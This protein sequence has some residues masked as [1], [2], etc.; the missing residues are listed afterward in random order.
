MTMTTKTRT[1]D[2]KSALKVLSVLN[3]L[4]RNFAYGFT[5]T[6]LQR[7]T[8]LSASNITVYTNTLINAG[9]AERIP[10][11]DRVRP[12]HRLAQQAIKILHSLDDAQKRIDESRN[13]LLRG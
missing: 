7:E 11:T 13:R 8:G 9:F 10:E 4:M 2:T 3:V 12:I 6:E 1:P 5:N